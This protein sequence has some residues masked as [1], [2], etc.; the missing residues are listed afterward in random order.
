MNYTIRQLQVFKAVADHNSFTKASEA[1]HL[2][3]PA[4]SIQ[5]KSFTEQFDFPLI[6]YHGRELVLTEFGHRVLK[7]V[8]SIWDKIEALSTINQ[9]AFEHLSGTLKVASVSTGKYIMPYFLTT[10]LQ[11]NP[12][13]NLS[14]DVTNKRSVTQSLDENLIDFALVSTLPENLECHEEVL[15]ENELVLVSNAEKAQEISHA[16]LATQKFLLREAG[17]ATR[18]AME[19][20]LKKSQL[21]SSNKITLTSNEAVKQSV[22]AGL[23]ISVMPLI[24]IR[25]ELERGRLKII[26]H[27]KLPIKSSWRLIWRSDKSF[28]PVAKAFLDHIKDQKQNIMDTYF[29]D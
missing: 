19:Q 6:E 26:P 5:F 3:Q 10:F 8:N 4:I 27:E 23:G 9:S 21:K 24:G 17:S 11:N 20:F 29:V 14:M 25:S 22:L 28:S 16:N 13:V 2:T 12:G 7:E 15:M 1:L 18:Q